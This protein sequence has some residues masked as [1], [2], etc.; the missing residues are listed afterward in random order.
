MGEPLKVHPLLGCVSRRSC[1]KFGG[2]LQNNEIRY[3]VFWLNS[4]LHEQD[5]SYWSITT[6]K[7]T[8]RKSPHAGLLF[9]VDRKLD[10]C[11]LLHLIR[12]PEDIF[13]T[14]FLEISLCHARVHPTAA[15][16]IPTGLAVG[17]KHKR[18]FYHSN[19]DH[20]SYIFDDTNKFG[21]RLIFPAGF[22]YHVIWRR[23]QNV[24]SSSDG[25]KGEAS[26]GE[27]TISICSG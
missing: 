14:P 5:H 1:A 17:L 11:W 3:P 23:H 6:C 24:T 18:G 16:E 9:Q 7:A 21:N 10:T 26:K 13:M 20:R 2:R 22:N 8:K 15:V 19:Y 27:I 4:T 25:H 12:C